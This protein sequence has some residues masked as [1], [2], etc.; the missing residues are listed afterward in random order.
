M[1]RFFLYRLAALLAGLSVVVAIGWCSG[2]E[3]RLDAVEAARA[4]LGIALEAGRADVGAVELFVVQAGPAEGPPVVLLHGFP[5]F[6]YAWKGAIAPLAA[7]GF[8]VIVP[9]QRG[10]GDSD[11]PPGVAA[12]DVD[13]L[14]DDV[15]GLIAALG[16]ERA[17]VAAHDWGGGVAWNLAIRHPERVRKL[18]VIDTSHPDAG[19][20]RAS[21]E[22]T[23]SWY[24]TFFQI[25]WL[26]EWSARL[27]HWAILSKMLR[28]TSRPGAFP[29]EKLALYRSAWDRD[30]AFGTMVNW[31][32][33]AFRRPP[34]DSSAPLRRVA[35]P[36][37]LIAA[38]DDAFIPGDLTRASL[39]L[40]D[41]GR[42]V[43]LDAGTHWVLQEEPEKI[44]ALLADFFREP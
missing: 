3:P 34:P 15:A 23:I 12:Y 6:W 1:R 17:A 30:G 25:P 9:D 13:A 22:Q 16:H 42:L 28:D 29:D 35:V 44:A 10:Y 36:T 21:H 37:L 38:P 32:R 26:P 4:E 2:R 18:A 5:E 43:E 39:E 7:A 27:G 20:L 33:A 11:K 24:R 8:R 19:R 31:Y 40:L 41:D 14:G